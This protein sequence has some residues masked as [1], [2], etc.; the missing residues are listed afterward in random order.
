MLATGCLGVAEINFQSWN[1]VKMWAMSVLVVAA[2]A[3]V[4]VVVVVV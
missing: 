2:A 4:A 1:E 3:V